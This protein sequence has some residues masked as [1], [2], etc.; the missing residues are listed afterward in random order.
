VG[1]RVVNWNIAV[2]EPI[3]KKWIG[4]VANPF[5]YSSGALVGIRG[6]SVSFKP[7]DVW[8]MPPG[9]KGTVVEL[10]GSEPNP[11]NLYEAQKAALAKQSR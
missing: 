5:A 7:E 8:A 10:A 3:R 4:L 1:R 2:Q 6:A 9:D 11:P